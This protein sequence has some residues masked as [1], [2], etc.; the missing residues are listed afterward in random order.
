MQQ[1]RYSDGSAGDVDYGAIGSSYVRFRQPEPAIATQILQAL[2]HAKTVLNVG[3][4][5]GSYEPTDRNVTAVE[6][7]ASMRAQR[8]AHLAVAIDAVAEALPFGDRSFDASMATV[9]VHQ[10]S[11]LEK[12]LS[13]M[14]R[15]TRGPV[16]LLLCDPDRMADYWLND[17]IP[18]VRAIEASR[19]PSIGRV[20][21]ALDGAAE[22]QPVPVPLLCRDGFNE[23][24]YGRPEALLDPM[25]RLACS[26]WSL[27]P[28]A[29]VDRFVDHLSRDLATGY[30]DE[31]YGHLRSQPYF[32]GPLRLIIADK[33][34]QGPSLLEAGSEKAT[35][36]MRGQS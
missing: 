14:R 10:W 28:E 36:P 6:P 25:A 23:A 34:S 16:V 17:Y 13:E 15:V 21:D 19:F 24:Y 5:A 29:A 11:D 26:S 4:G 2:G 31:H 35:V 27:V 22:V 3:A 32:D 7:S 1:M 20:V 30:W 9:T 33:S 12:G 18:E 8:P